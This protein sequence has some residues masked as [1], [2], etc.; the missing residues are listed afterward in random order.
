MIN[1]RKNE[2]SPDK[3]FP[4]GDTLQET[5]DALGMSQSELATR[6]K[7]TEKQVNSI[8][9]GK[10]SISEVTALKLERVLGVDAS[11][12]RNLEHNYR[13]DISIGFTGLD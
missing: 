5:I 10:T 9:K 1:G 4:P 7:V 6:M 13:R 12:W 2:Y 8:I 11:F 3:V